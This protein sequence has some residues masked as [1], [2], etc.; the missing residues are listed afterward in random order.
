MQV[1][2]NFLEDSEFI[3]LKNIILNPS[4]LWEYNPNTTSDND[5]KEFLWNTKFTHCSFEDFQ[6]TSA[7]NEFSSFI[8]D[9]RLEMNCLKRLIINSYNWTSK[10]YQHPTHADYSF[11]HKGAILNFTT[12][13]G[14][15][16][17]E[18]ERIPSVAN[19][20]ILHDPSKLHCGTTT[21]TAKRRIIANFNYF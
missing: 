19:R 12:C 16:V 20:V 10:I 14:Y 15:T 2:D 21:T 9:P 18:N 1:I 11:Q 5:P 13:D 6:K 3:R 4:F 17:V 7:V 8:Q